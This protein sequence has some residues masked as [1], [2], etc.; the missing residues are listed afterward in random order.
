MIVYYSE[1]RYKFIT[2]D[3]K[4]IG[5]CV[6]HIKI[7]KVNDTFRRNFKYTK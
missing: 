1:Y 3:L 4:V 2:L 7:L 6:K 5:Q